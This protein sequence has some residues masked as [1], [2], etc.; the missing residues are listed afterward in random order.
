MSMSLITLTYYLTLRQFQGSE[1]RGGAV[2]FVVVGQSPA[3][4]LL[5]RQARLGAI[6]SLNLALFIHAQYD[7][8]LRGIQIQTN[9]VG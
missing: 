1:Q 5:H 4:A 6:Q 8:L 3:A 2:A 9:H 7:R